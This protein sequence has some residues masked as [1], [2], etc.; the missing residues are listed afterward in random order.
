MPIPSPYA[1]VP[2]SDKIRWLSDEEHNQ[3]QV[4]HDVPVN[5]GWSGTFL[6]EVE[7]LTPIFIGNGKKDDK[8]SL[9]AFVT[10]SGQP[11]VPG[12][13]LRGMLRNV[14]EIASMGAMRR[15]RVGERAFGVRDLHNRELYIDHM[16]ALKKVDGKSQPVPL[17][18]AGWLQKK[19]EIDDLVSTDG[20]ETVA[21]IAPVD[22]FKV[23]YNLILQS[24]LAPQHYGPG[25]RQSAI[26]KYEAW[27]GR[28]LAVSFDADVWDKHGAAVE[29]KPPRIGNYGRVRRLGQVDQGQLSRKGTLV[30]T[31]QP[32]QW[33]PGAVARPGA[34][35]PKH[36]DFVFCEPS[37]DRQLL[38]VSRRVFRFFEGAH[39]SGREQHQTSID[40]NAEWAFWKRKYDSGERVPVFFLLRQDGL[41]AFGLSMMFR[42][43][44][45]F[46]THDALRNTQPEFDDKRLDLA[47]AIFG[48]VR[49]PSRPNPGGKREPTD[50]LAGR[51]SFGQGNLQGTLKKSDQVT[52]IPG[53]PKASYYP[54]YIAQ[55]TDS[56]GRVQGGGYKTLMN[57]DAQLAGWKRYRPQAPVA[58]PPIPASVKSKEVFATFEP[59]N[60]GT[61]FVSEVRVHNLAEH[62][63]GALL[64]AIRLGDD[65]EAVHLLGG[66][67]P[68]GYGQVKLRVKDWHVNPHSDWP[69]DPLAD[70]P[71][72]DAEADQRKLLTSYEAWME[73]TGLSVR[74]SEQRRELLAIA[75]PLPPGS[76]DGR[77]PTLDGVNEFIEIK[78]QKLALPLAS[79]QPRQLRRLAQT[80]TARPA[81]GKVAAGAVVAPAA[82]T[83]VGEWQ[84]ATVVRFRDAKVRL[85]TPG[86][87]N[88]DVVLDTRIFTEA[89]WKKPRL[90]GNDFPANRKVEI[91]LE[92]LQVRRVRPATT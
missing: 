19:P 52:W 6:L 92:G 7:A 15:L 77:Y 28:S 70:L 49:E 71:A 48:R 80:A 18:C 25:Q 5:D 74:D 4:S 27:R 81:V 41:R 51:V 2:T 73:Q 64:W 86:G 75:R 29:G 23:D 59:L 78:K 62:E 33:R 89:D 24:G 66:A 63:L 67:R 30:M 40:P 79:E 68:I 47:E 55:N 17:V 85:V 46:D 44:Y 3:T 12:A 83:A 9:R 88:L 58:K 65:V 39:A 82:T 8:T 26:Q 60:K 14:V 72:R 50:A 36:H 10:S 22:F 90:N 91:L 31:G 56:M 20:D 34:G 38:P 61:R 35:Q 13:S 21:T 42:L 32:Q 53:A 37:S 1:F 16:A 11:V 69:D 57:P 76:K 54:N 45:N 43:A 84:P 87:V